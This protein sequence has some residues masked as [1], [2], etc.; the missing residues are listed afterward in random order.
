MSSN[1]YAVWYNMLRRCR[2]PKNTGYKNYGGRGIK[3]CKRWETFQN[4][5]DDMAPTSKKGLTLDRIDN[6][7][8][9]EPKNCRWAT[10]KQQNNNRR[11]NHINNPCLVCP[12]ILKLR[13]EGYSLTDLGLI[14]NR[15]LVTIKYHLKD[16]PNHLDYRYVLEPK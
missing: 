5:Y 10:R 1:L 4:F 12:H 15:H 7:G 6:N 9:Y 13:K 2:D 14:F 11:D 3:V 16:H 8:N